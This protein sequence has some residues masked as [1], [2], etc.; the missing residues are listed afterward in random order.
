MEVLILFAVKVMSII[1]FK[2][3]LSVFLNTH[4]GKI[5]DF[6]NVRGWGVPKEKRNLISYKTKTFLN[7]N[8]LFLAFLQTLT[9][10]DDE[11]LCSCAIIERV[12]KSNKF[13]SFPQRWAIDDLFSTNIRL[14][15]VPIMFQLCSNKKRMRE[16]HMIV[17][18][19]SLQ[20]TYNML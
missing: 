12:C 14:T 13:L 1:I 16:Q 10:K 4:I 18:N 17:S 8:M 11:W 2:C 19:N 3:N 6:K 9:L 7:K 15:L 5:N 20:W